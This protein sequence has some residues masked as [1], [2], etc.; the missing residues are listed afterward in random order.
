MTDFNDI[1][2]RVA[3]TGILQNIDEE[4]QL[5][6]LD[7]FCGEVVYAIKSHTH[8]WTATALYMLSEE[9]MRTLSEEAPNLDME[10]LRQVGVGCFVCQEPYDPRLLKRKCKGEPKRARR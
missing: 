4:R 7:L 6:K 8:L 9:T 10:N 1:T 3:D 5:T 2:D